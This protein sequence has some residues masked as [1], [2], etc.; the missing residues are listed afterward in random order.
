M[1]RA[2]V[3]QTE[4]ERERGILAVPILKILHFSVQVTFSNNPLRNNT[5][6]DFVIY[7]KRLPIK[8]SFKLF[9]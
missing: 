1:P 7:L 3:R 2:R 8:G 4:R 5:L 6:N 9:L